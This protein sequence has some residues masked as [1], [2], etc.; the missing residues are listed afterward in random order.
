[1]WV[2]LNLRQK[3]CGLHETAALGCESRMFETAVAG[4]ACTVFVLYC[5]I[6]HCNNLICCGAS[7]GADHYWDKH[8]Q[9]ATR[10]I[11]VGS[12]GARRLI[13]VLQVTARWL[14]KELL[15]LTIE[16]ALAGQQVRSTFAHWLHYIRAMFVEDRFSPLDVV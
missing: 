14:A 7:L 1:M 2:K 11:T 12:R 6:P 8:L 5:L 10:L 3:C 13:T 9:I 4:Y 15:C 16:T